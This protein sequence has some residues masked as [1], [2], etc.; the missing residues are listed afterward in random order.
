MRPRQIEMHGRAVAQPLAD[1][2][3]VQ[4]PNL[5]FCVDHRHN[6]RTDKMFMPGLAHDARVPQAAAERLTRFHFFRGQTVSQRAVGK[7]QLK[8]R[9]QFRMVQPPPG[10]I[11][12]CFRRA[13]QRMVIELNHPVQQRLPPVL[14]VCQHLRL[15]GGNQRRNRGAAA[16]FP[17]QVLNRMTQAQPFSFHHPVQHRAAGIAAEAVIKVF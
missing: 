10:Q 1:F 3:P 14:I 11:I 8:L 16:Q 17:A 13:Q 6:Q 7:T 9:D 5:T 4:L 2:T 12:L 15:S